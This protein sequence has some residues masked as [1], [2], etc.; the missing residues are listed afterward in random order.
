MLSI[1]EVSNPNFD[2]AG[3]L[4]V[5]ITLDDVVCETHTV[6]IELAAEE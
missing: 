1:F 3:E 4:F 5:E 6:L 2:R